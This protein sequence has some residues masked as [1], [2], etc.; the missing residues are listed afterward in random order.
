MHFRRIAE[1]QRLED[2]DTESE[3]GFYEVQ[4]TERLGS[5]AIPTSTN[6]FACK[7]SNGTVSHQ[8]ESPLKLKISLVPT[9]KKS[10]QNSKHPKTFDT[11]SSSNQVVV[12][13]TN[14]IKTFRNS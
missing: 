3:E 1:Q 2:D 7:Y 4:S 8:Q 9:T 13:N 6:Q 11:L 14:Q 10:D 12:N 5:K